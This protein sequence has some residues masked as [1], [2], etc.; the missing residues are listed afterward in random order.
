LRNKYNF[1]GYI[2]AK[3][4]PGTSADLIKQIGFLADRIS[5]NLELPSQKSLTRLAPQK[6]KDLILK[7]MGFIANQIIENSHAL[8][9][10]FNG[11]FKTIAPIKNT[12]SKF[13]PA[14][15]STQI[16]IGA[17]PEDDKHILT[18]VENLYNKYKLKRIF[19]SAYMPVSDDT[20][21]PAPTTPPPLLRQHRLY[22]ADWLMRFYKFKSCEIL[23][24]Q[25][26]MLSPF[27]DPKCNWALKHPEFFPIEI[28]AASYDTL[29]RIP[30]IGV[31]SVR[32]ILMARKNQ[33]LDFE[34]LKKLGVVL[35]RAK[36]FILCKGKKFDSLSFHKTDVLQALMSQRELQIYSSFIK[37]VL[38]GLFD[39]TKVL[40]NG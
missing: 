28:N 23:D 32:N 9:P 1:V 31:K 30:G 5:I 38:P 22:Q 29:L 19:Y 18:L 7:P 2:H 11:S 4:I 12:Q 40:I 20:A 6:N 27:I 35:K 13:A 39:T 25:T 36:Y 14:G 10:H 21:L 26:P 16:I 37:P 15:Q 33:S 34:D 3:A 17:S 24:D 8:S